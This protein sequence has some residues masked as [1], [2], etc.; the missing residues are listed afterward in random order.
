MSSEW[1]LNPGFETRKKCHFPPNRGVPSVEVINTKIMSTI[2]ISLI[3]GVL[4]NRGVP[5]SAL[6]KGPLEETLR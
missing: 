3:G 5:N 6:D 1:S 4:L 2:F